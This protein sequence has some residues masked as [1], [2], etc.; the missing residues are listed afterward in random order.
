MNMVDLPFNPILRSQ[1]IEKLVMAG[2]ERRYYRFRYAKFYNGIITADASG[3]NLLCAYCW[4]YKKNYTI[5]SCEDKFYSSD[6]VAEKIIKLMEKHKTDRYRI[7][8]CEAILGSESVKHLAKIIKLVGDG[9]IVETNGIILGYQPELLQRIPKSARI[10]LTIK[11]D[12]P[13]AFE[14][15]TGARASF[16]KYQIEAIRALN[17]SERP[18]T[19]ALMK[20]FVDMLKLGEQIDNAGFEL[21][22]NFSVDVE[23]LLYYPQNIASMKSRGFKPIYSKEHFQ[24]VLNS[25]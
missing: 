11:A 14:L 10:R 12:G 6:A 21:N 17:D 15:I 1:E 24:K 23:G 16:F 3:C 9:C 18:Y 25:V 22:D 7:S 13:K 2:D 8:G 19:I 5:E 20:Q 4:N